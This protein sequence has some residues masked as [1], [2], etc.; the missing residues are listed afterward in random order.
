MAVAL[1][2][3]LPIT[4]LSSFCFLVLTLLAYFCWGR[5]FP[6]RAGPGQEN[7]EYDVEEI[8]GTT[9]FVMV[10]RKGHGKK[11]KKPKLWDIWVS[12][13]SGR[14]TPERK[15]S[16]GSSFTDLSVGNDAGHWAEL[17]V[18]V[19]GSKLRCADFRALSP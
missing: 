17:K 14:P 8:P 15:L 18:G 7:P 16:S 9:D 4:F 6:Q 19:F 12:N 5:V 2:N 3:I 11:V 13:F 1:S 10:G